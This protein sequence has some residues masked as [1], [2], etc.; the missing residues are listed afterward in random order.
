MI[1]ERAYHGMSYAIVRGNSNRVCYILLPEGL[2]K[3]ALDVVESSALKYDCNVILVT[4]MNWN[5][6]LTPWP[7]PG[8]F[9]KEKPFGGHA[10]D[11]LKELMSDAFP[12]LETSLNLHNPQR[13]LVGI[14][15]SGLFALWAIFET[16][17]FKAVASISGSLWYDKLEEWIKER[18]MVNTSA[19][20]HLSLGDKEKNSKNA[21]MANVEDAT[22]RIASLLQ[23]RG[24][25]VDY[26][27]V[28]GTHFSP[29]APRLEL[30][31][32]S[33]LERELPISE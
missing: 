21:R 6:D 5:D 3:D 33:I 20:I 26:Q 24:L 18:P 15:L 11:F 9:R 4:G 17:T 10:K 7:A 30:A 31:L 1:E 12:G 23:D 14:S 8:V 32:A 27:I 25:R 13:Y 2:N 22:S 16:N 19:R 29:V 28:Q